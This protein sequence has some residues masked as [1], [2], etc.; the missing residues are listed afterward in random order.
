V[1]RV[2]LPP[3]R[4]QQ[5]LHRKS[6]RRNVGDYGITAITFA[7]C[8]TTHRCYGLRQGPRQRSHALPSVRALVVLV[9]P[10]T[11][12]TSKIDALMYACMHHM[13]A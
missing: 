12:T 5:I 9:L 2:L 3:S 11:F 4:R 7:R 8:L 13:Y 10:Q 1:P 6:I